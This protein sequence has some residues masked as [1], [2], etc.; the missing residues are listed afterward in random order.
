MVEKIARGESLYTS[1]SK[2]NNA[3]EQIDQAKTDSEKALSQSLST[4]R[5]L[6]RIVIENGTSDA[7]VLQARIKNDGTEFDVLADRLAASDT[8]IGNLQADAARVKNVVVATFFPNIKADGATDDAPGIQELFNLAAT[9]DGVKIVFPAGQYTLESPLF[10]SENT[11]LVCSVGAK[12]TKQHNGPMLLNLK[13]TDSMTAYNGN[14]NITIKSG[15]WDANFPAYTGGSSFVLAHAKNILIE[16]TEFHNISGGHAI[17]LNA[18]Q[19]AIVNKCGF[20]GFDDEGGARSY[21]EAVQIDLAK[22]ASAFPW[23]GSVFDHT[24]CKDIWVT[25]CRF[26]ASE[27]L[28]SWGRAVGS[29]SAT[30]GKQHKNI[31]I[32]NNVVEG[33][34]EWAFRAYNWQ[35]YS[36]TNNK[37]FNCGR[38]INVRTAI[39]GVDTQNSSGVASES[40]ICEG[41]I[42][43]NNT[44]E[45]GLT[46]G[47]GIEIYGEEGTT[48]KNKGIAV[49]GNT[50]IAPDTTFD[51][52]NITYSDSISLIGNYVN[53]VNSDGIL[54]KSISNYITV[55][56]NIIASVEGY[57]IQIVGG[58]SNMNVNGNNINRVGKSGIYASEASTRNISIANNNIVGVNGLVLAGTDANHIRLTGGVDRAMVLGNVFTNAPGYTTTHAIYVTNGCTNVGAGDNMAIGMTIYNA[59]VNGTVDSNGNMT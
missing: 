30:I 32:D 50:I 10:I 52:I 42:I 58:S 28:G 53:G 18:I 31:T 23:G 56:G 37:I 21:S 5:Q 15:V 22:D 38:G 7:E 46:S 16:E 49:I 24:P 27:T 48:G 17:E 54:I 13:S 29:H 8:L 19:N 1:Y 43:S 14:G 34:L 35:Q 39:T 47:R 11:H 36:I 45:G 9:Y 44:I 55:I 4:S 57:G 6:S 3:I 59:A 33:T 51:G 2:V 20:L 12:F 26:G 25:N 40:E 41:G